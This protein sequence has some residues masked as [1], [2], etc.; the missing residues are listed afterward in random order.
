M[1]E[2]DPETIIIT[3]DD[4]IV[5]P[6][7]LVEKLIARHKRHPN[8]AIGS[9]GVKLGAFPFYLS[10][11]HNDHRRNK[12]WYSFNVGHDGEPV[13]VLLESSGV[14]YLRKF[15]DLQ[16]IFSEMDEIESTDILVSGIL[17]KR[18]I[19]RY[20]F[21]MPPVSMRD[22]DNGGVGFMDLFRIWRLRLFNDRVSFT[23][24][25]TITYPVAIAV[26]VIVAA[27]LLFSTRSSGVA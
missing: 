10:C 20:I 6:E 9:S 25:A 5:Y 11:A 17:S 12:S 24:R 27:A 22:D 19:D 26:A 23:R 21:R 18:G 8:A 15:F 13:D 7:T 14:L 3:L 1:V 4:D 2:K 16:E